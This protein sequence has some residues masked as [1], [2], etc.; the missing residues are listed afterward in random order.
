MF[1]SLLCVHI[2]NSFNL[3]VTRVLYNKTV[4]VC[5]SLGR[6]VAF[7]GNG[8]LSI[9]PRDPNLTTTLL[10]I[11][12]VSPASAFPSGEKSSD[13]FVAVTVIV[14]EEKTVPINTTLLKSTGPP[15]SEQRNQNQHGE[16]VY[17][18][19]ETSI[20]NAFTS[21]YLIEVVGRNITRAARWLA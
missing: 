9:P 4:A 8:P 19:L 10:L 17:T 11:N 18:V 1:A 3:S 16:S 6:G 5:L 20:Y 12:P 13:H 21:V 2:I 14:I 7:F 15:K